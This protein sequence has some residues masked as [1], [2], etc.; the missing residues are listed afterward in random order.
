M[1]DK[2]RQIV[3][4]MLAIFLTAF[5][6]T[7]YASDKNCQEL[8]K[9]VMELKG[10]DPAVYGDHPCKAMPDDAGK[11]IMVL[12]DEI[13]VVRTDSGEILS[14]GPR[15][16]TPVGS[17]A[18]SIDT[19]PY[20]LTPTVRAFGV[21]FSAYYPHYHAGEEH[22]TMNMYVIEGENIRPV[23][24][25]LIARLDLSGEQCKDDAREEDCTQSV[26]TFQSKINVAKTR[27]N[28][29]A[30]MIVKT[31]DFSGK[32]VHYTLTYDASHYVGPTDAMEDPVNPAQ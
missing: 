10:D 29:Y 5:A 14:H 30:D 22:Q 20:W 32:A 11:T 3:K 6:T 16:T 1:I 24:E 25:L 19:A 23:M 26:E 7:A 13:A 17:Y 28:G 12:G 9:K 31:R 15:G 21:R 18:T 2:G 8:A 4:R 27:H